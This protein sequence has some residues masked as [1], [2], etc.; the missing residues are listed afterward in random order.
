VANATRPARFRRNI[1]VADLILPS[2]L[3]QERI[4]VIFDFADVLEWQETISDAVTSVTVSS[5]EDNSPQLILYKTT[6]PLVTTAVQQFQEGVPGVIYKVQCTVRGSTGE[7]YTKTAV[8]A[9]LPSEGI[10]P[11]IIAT[12][13]TSRPYPVDV[14]E[15]FDTAAIP[16]FGQIYQRTLEG[17]DASAVIVSGELVRVLVQYT[18]WPFEG[19]DA[20]AVI[21]SGDLYS[22]LVVYNKGLPEGIDCAALIATGDLFNSLITYTTGLPEG[23]DTSAEIV[24][25]SLV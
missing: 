22:N 1:S 2:K 24:S 23:I 16:I 21:I 25:G 6:V 18:D 12:F 3:I 17:I 4:E 5:G 14:I 11:P 8:L 19:I 15:S 7:I 9:I 10:R 20:A 13:L